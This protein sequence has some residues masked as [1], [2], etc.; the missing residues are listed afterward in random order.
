MRN[1]VAEEQTMKRPRRN[2]SEK[3]KWVLMA[4]AAPAALRAVV[5]AGPISRGEVSFTDMFV[6][7]R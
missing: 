5:R 1:V 4:I 2:H 3:F 6:T 7:Q